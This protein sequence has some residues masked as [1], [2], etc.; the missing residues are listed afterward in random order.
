MMAPNLPM[1]VKKVINS[2]TVKITNAVTYLP[3]V[4]WNTTGN[5]VDRP[6]NFIF[7]LI[8]KGHDNYFSLILTILNLMK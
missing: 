8:G 6:Q 4:V 5:V 2:S 1:V 3:W 7:L